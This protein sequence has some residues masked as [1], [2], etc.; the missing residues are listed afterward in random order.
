MRRIAFIPA[1]AGSVRIPFKNIRPIGGHPL[2]AYSVNAAVKSGCF[3]KVVCS[4]NSAVIAQIAEHYEAETL[5]RPA[6]YATSSSPDIQWVRHALDALERH[7]DYD[8]FSII[9]PTSPFRRPDTVQRAMAQWDSFH[10]PTA[11]ESLRAVERT[12]LTPFKMWVVRFGTMHPLIPF[13]PESQPWHSSQ[14]ATLPDIWVQNA[15]LEIAW[16]D[17]VRRLGTIAGERVMP[18][19]TEE[20]EG[21]DLSTMHDWW[22]AEMMIEKERWALPPIDQTPW[23][24]DVE[25]LR[26]VAEDASMDLNVEELAWSL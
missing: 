3:D 20:D 25:Q 7:S 8:A 22:F 13:G 14:T 9:R 16:T 12:S 2:L 23:K 5:I 10:D 18:F 21:F 19:F 1:R 11:Y 17:T 4:T 26:R 24:V 6:E 15:S